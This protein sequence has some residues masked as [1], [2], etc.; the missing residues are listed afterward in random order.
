MLPLG[1]SWERSWAEFMEGGFGFAATET[2]Y[3]I[4]T[5]HLGYEVLETVSMP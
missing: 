1:S 5:R 3:N 2:Y 4:L